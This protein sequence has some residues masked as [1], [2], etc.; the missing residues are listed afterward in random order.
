LILPRRR[1]P[2]LLII[3][4]VLLFIIAQTALASVNVLIDERSSQ[5]T[6]TVDMAGYQRTLTQRMLAMA[7]LMQRYEH[8][9]SAVIS[10]HAELVASAH[11]FDVTLRAFQRG[12]STDDSAGE[13]VDIRALHSPGEHAILDRINGIW[14]LLRARI[15]LLGDVVPTPRAIDELANSANTTAAQ[16]SV[17]MNGLSGEIRKSSAQELVR[18]GAR[19]DTLV[20]WTVLGLFGIILGFFMRVVDGRRE[21]KHIADDLRERNEELARSASAL[22]L[23]KSQQ[24]RIMETVRQGLF[25]IDADSVIQGEYSKELERIFRATDLAGGRFLDLLQRVLSPKFFDTSRDYMALLFDTG[26][27]ERTVLDVNPLDE[28]EVNF[29]DPKGGFIARY[30]SFSFRRIVEEGCVMRVFVAVTDVTDRVAL[31]RNK[32]ESDQRQQ[33]RLELLMSVLH[34]D[35]NAQAEFI[36]TTNEQLRDMNEAL[37]AIVVAGR[38]M[39]HEDIL[40]QRLETVYRCVHNIKGNASVLRVEYFRK[41]AEQFEGKIAELRSRARLAGDD[42]I[43]VAVLQAEMRADL[44]ELQE[45]RRRLSGLQVPA[46]L[47]TNKAPTYPVQRGSLIP[48]EGVDEHAADLLF[49]NLASFSLELGYRLGKEIALDTTR[50]RTREFNAK[51]RHVLKDVFIQIVRNAVVHGIERPEVRLSLGKPARGTILLR[52]L[53]TEENFVSF[54]CRD[55]GRGIDIEVLRRTAVT[56]GIITEEEADKMDDSAAAGLIF[57]PGFTTANTPNDAAGRGMGMDVV[58]NAIV[59]RL[60][61]EINLLSE[62]GSF[63]E[64]SF[65]LP[66][67]ILTAIA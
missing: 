29:P 61:G 32:R 34:V 19:R 50:L 30:L 60:G 47:P 63:F 12:G 9:G 59:D 1:L 54:S 45:L 40:R 51:Q 24:D 2:L 38:D 26:K 3:F 8:Q 18:L 25:L 13:R 46:L 20:L 62:P 65:T 64:L 5:A 49:D 43:V 37:R 4:G 27:R 21:I 44:D 56:A 6:T 10:P 33:R 16:L 23:A 31:E 11:A 15:V 48:V 66:V 58:R 17:L 7:L 41:A 67:S 57:C 55:D 39:R 42:F 28:I 22:E 35:A 14:I 53:S 36:T 52:S